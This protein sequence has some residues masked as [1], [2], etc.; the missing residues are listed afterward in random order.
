M[1]FSRRL[2]RGLVIMLGAVVMAAAAVWAAW[3]V[4]V[5]EPGRRN[6]WR[7]WESASPAE[8]GLLAQALATSADRSPHPLPLMSESTLSTGPCD[9]S[10]WGLTLGRVSAARFAASTK[11]DH[12]QVGYLPHLTLTAPNYSAL[13]LRAAVEV[14][15]SLGWDNGMAK[16]CY[17][18]RGLTDWRLEHCRTSWRA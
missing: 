5:P 14:G 7:S 8:C 16:V 18:R 2:A 3:A 17:F 10:H 1:A 13:R 6:G 15:R 11:G 12:P 9:W 4:D